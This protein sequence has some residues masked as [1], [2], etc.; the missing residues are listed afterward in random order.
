[1]RSR[2]ELKP[3]HLHMCWPE[4]KCG[5]LTYERYDVTN[6]P[7]DLD[8]HLYWKDKWY[9]HQCWEFCRSEGILCWKL[10]HRDLEG[11]CRCLQMWKKILK[12]KQKNSENE[13]PTW[14]KS[15]ERHP[16]SV[17]SAAHPWVRHNPLVRNLIQQKSLDARRV[18]VRHQHCDIH[19]VVDK[20]WQPVHQ[21]IEQSVF[22][23]L[24]FLFFSN[25]MFR[26]TG[27]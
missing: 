10:L 11:P 9:H 7:S 14:I 16:A 24:K 22:I 12:K 21:W 20:V 5:I 18:P 25:L 4:I 6:W 27:R 26:N 15:K 17:V 8:V 13:F 19:V 3:V 23:S 1:M 2:P